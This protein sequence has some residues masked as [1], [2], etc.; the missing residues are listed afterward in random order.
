MNGYNK[1]GNGSSL[2]AKATSLVTI[3]STLVGLC[4][5]AVGGIV[6]TSVNNAHRDW[7]D[8]DHEKRLLAIEQQMHVVY[9]VRDSVARIEGA[10]G[11]K[12]K[13]E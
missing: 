13:G 5:G 2:V 4:C 12:K 8:A 3:G 7:V 9:D 6:V 10:L 1:D 11:I